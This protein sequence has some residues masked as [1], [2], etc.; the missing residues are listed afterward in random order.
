MKH[1]LYASLA[2]LLAVAGVGL[3]VAA[4]GGPTGDGKPVK[5]SDD[6][7]A[8]GK[9]LAKAA[10]CAACH[11][12]PGGAPYAGGHPLESPFGSLYGSNITPDPEHGIGRWSKDDFYK[13]MHDGTSPGGK[14]LYPAMPY[15]SYRAMPREDVDA[16]YDYL[17]QQPAVA[18]PNKAAD[19]HFP[20][21]VRFGV[22]FWKALFLKDELPAASQGTSAEWTRGRYVANVLGH[23]AECH[24]PRGFMGQMDL[25]LQWQGAQ[26]GRWLAPDITPKGLAERGWTARDIETFMKTGIS[27]QGS[28]WG[29]MHTVIDLSTQHLTDADSKAMVTFMTGD[30]PLAPQAPVEDPGADQKFAAGRQTYLNVC[31]GCHAVNGEGKGHVAIPM[32][33][34][35][36]LRLGDPRNLVVSIIDGIPTQKFPGLERMEEMPGF[37]NKLSDVEIADLTNYL[38]VRFGGQPPS[39]TRETVAKLRHD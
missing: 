33:G 32:A 4:C 12:A 3:V 6:Q 25:G 13:A 16:V 36:T 24:T 10:D 34:N 19:L 23:C 2:R 29:E 27:P 18:Q 38:R 5:A 37:A 21:N 11:T 15:A 1:P 22:W 9:Y 20:Y 39:V 30:K 26:I 35:S 28:A 8:R 17:M 14:Q 31:A 7:I